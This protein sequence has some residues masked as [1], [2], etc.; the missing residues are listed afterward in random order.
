M[1]ICGGGRT[2]KAARNATADIVEVMTAAENVAGL[3]HR[4]LVAKLRAVGVGRNVAALAIRK[5]IDENVLLITK[6]A[7][8]SDVH[9]LNPSRRNG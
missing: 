1:T 6:G 3:S 4:Q 5:A 7:R 2:D 9:I 8:N